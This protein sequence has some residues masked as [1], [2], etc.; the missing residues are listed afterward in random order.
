MDA[1]PDGNLETPQAP[2]L[3]STTVGTTSTQQFYSAV[4]TVS[5][6]DLKFIYFINMWTF[7]DICSALLSR[8]QSTCLH[9][10]GLSV[11]Y[12]YC[13]EKWF[14]RLSTIQ[15]K[16]KLCRSSSITRFHFVHVHCTDTELANRFKMGVS[17][18]VK[19]RPDLGQPSLIPRQY[20]RGCVSYT[21]DHYRD[22]P[23]GFAMIATALCQSHMPAKVFS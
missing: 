12:V 2:F 11:M 18:A 16:G 1:L 9:R 22:E 3:P 7:F 14:V 21:C 17:W 5:L 23:L 8:D 4:S 6:S 15:N 13:T 10:F 19:S 20:I